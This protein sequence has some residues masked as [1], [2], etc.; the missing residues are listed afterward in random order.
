M[1]CPVLWSALFAI[2]F[3]LEFIKPDFGS[4]EVSCFESVLNSRKVVALFRCAKPSHSTSARSIFHG[5]LVGASS[6]T[7]DLE[8]WSPGLRPVLSTLHVACC[9]VSDRLECCER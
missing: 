7:L 4:F 6:Q 8:P 2:E 1:S 9:I 5:R 3:L